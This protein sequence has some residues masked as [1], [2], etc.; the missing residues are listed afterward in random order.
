[1]KTALFVDCCIRGEASRSRK[2]AEAFFAHLSR[3]YTVKRLAL[4]QEELPAL[5]AESLAQRDALL[6]AGRTEHP[7]FRYARE[8]A[9][10]ELVVVAAPFWDLSVPALLKLYIENVSV[11]GITFRS[12]QQGLQGLCRGTDLVFLTTRGGIYEEGSEWEQGVPYLRAV[13]RFFGFD[14]FSFVAVDGLDVQGFDGEGALRDG[15][16]RAAEL[17]QTLGG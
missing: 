7:R 9:A 8:L 12:T 3:D 16:R 17:A 4:M 10:A 15:C 13:G 14:R 1:M 6:R 2:L 11:E 5:T